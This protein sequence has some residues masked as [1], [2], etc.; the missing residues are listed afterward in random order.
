MIRF[1]LFLLLIGIVLGEI[2]LNIVEGDRVPETNDDFR[3][4]V[5]LQRKSGNS[6]RHHC[7]GSL[8]TPHWVLTA[9]H[10]VKYDTPVNVR[11]G[12]YD[13]QNGG[14]TRKVLKIKR[15]PK[16]YGLSNDIALLQLN[17]P[18]ENYPLMN[19]DLDGHF[20]TP[21]DELT[22]IGWGY[23]KEGNG[24]IERYLRMVNLSILT[25]ERCQQAY[26]DQITQQNLCTFGVWNKKTKQRGD[27]NSG[28]SGG[29]LVSKKANG[30]IVQVAMVS[31][32]RGAGR[33]DFPGVNVRVSFFKDFIEDTLEESPKV[34]PPKKRKRRRRRRGR[35]NRRRRRRRRRQSSYMDNDQL[36][37]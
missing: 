11:V 2:E 36:G 10:C 32:G 8:I 23:I 34:D 3:S 1:V 4:I 12:S 15:H 24:L 7:G 29:P 26:G 31:W 13:N 20:E 33:K 16:N 19:L 14:I 25:T 17:Q 5:S 22:A 18:V 27:S 6:W 21:G 37:G 35:R 9:G 28:D 30:D